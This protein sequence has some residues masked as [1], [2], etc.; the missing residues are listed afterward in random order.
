MWYME[1]DDGVYEEMDYAKMGEYQREHRIIQQD[2][3]GTFFI[4]TV[5]L[6]LDH[7]YG[8]GEPHIYET[9]IFDES[10]EGPSYPDWPDMYQERYSRW[11][12]AL[13]NHRRVLKVVQGFV[14]GD[15][16]EEELREE[17][18]GI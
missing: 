1:T 10:E 12:S 6:G 14:S 13:K 11:K 16:T 15:I 9:M 18:D 4:S 3:V 8:E 5:W 17:L 7:G 2:K